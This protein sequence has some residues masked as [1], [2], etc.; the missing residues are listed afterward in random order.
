[1]SIEISDDDDSFVQPQHFD[2]LD[3]SEFQGTLCLDSNNEPTEVLSVSSDAESYYTS[4]DDELPAV[5]L[6]TKKNAVK[7]LFAPKI[8]IKPTPSTSRI[9]NNRRQQIIPSITQVPVPPKLP[10]FQRMI[11][12]VLVELPVEPYGSQIALM[13]KV[14]SI[15]IL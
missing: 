1:M 12:G 7:N 5:N 15:L 2:Q 10:G 4:D 3:A 6:A 14:I 9:S 11:G 8:E 13:S